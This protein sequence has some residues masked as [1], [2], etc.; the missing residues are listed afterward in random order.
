MRPAHS[1]RRQS[2]WARLA[3]LAGAGCL[4]L[5]SSTGL[6]AAA[7]LTRAQHPSATA[8]QAI[9]G[10]IR[11]SVFPATNPINRDISQAAVDPR[12][13]SYIASI[14]ASGHLHPD[15]GSDPSYGI[16]YTVVGPRQAKV[17]IHVTASR[18]E[19]DSGPYP[20]P[21]GA[22]VE[23]AGQPGD[24]H[25]LV[26]QNGSCKLYELYDARRAG[27][28]WRAGSGAVFD[29]RRNALRPDA[30]PRPMPPGSR[31]SRCSSA[32]TTSRSA[33][34]TTRC[35]SRSRVPSAGTSTRPPI[36]PRQTP[37]RASRRWACGCG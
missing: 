24:R 26:V 37:I 29:L 35:A 17:P 2:A 28:G 8:R 22:S 36:S 23:G 33:K 30:G 9:P 27:A 20:I 1:V 19:S 10:R 34:S 7:R 18:A 21:P 11:C 25:V 13:A 32:L 5:T 4:A 16:P 15:W 14:G 3:L 12:S 31:S 6:I